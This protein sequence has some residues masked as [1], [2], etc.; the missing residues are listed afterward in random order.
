MGD[1]AIK[2]IGTLRDFAHLQRL[3]P[4]GKVNAV[5]SHRGDGL[6]THPPYN[7]VDLQVT[8]IRGRMS[9]DW[10]VTDG[11]FLDLSWNGPKSLVVSGRNLEPSLTRL[12]MKGYVWRYGI[13]IVTFINI[14]EKL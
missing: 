5:M 10:A 8:D 9:A 7:C 1:Y 14:K 4:D 11:E 6:L 12:P 3:S 2:R 13:Y